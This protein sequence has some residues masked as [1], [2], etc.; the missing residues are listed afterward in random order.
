MLVTSDEADAIMSMANNMQK[1]NRMSP[2]NNE[3][4][5]D[6]MN[7]FN[8]ARVK[9]VE[10]NDLPSLTNNKVGD[11]NGKSLCNGQHFSIYKN[12]FYLQTNKRKSFRREEN[13]Q[14]S[15]LCLLINV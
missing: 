7:I 3:N 11:D 1:V 9:K 4:G 8:V 6:K 12:R 13:L 10:L 15:D 5:T 14:N 2:S